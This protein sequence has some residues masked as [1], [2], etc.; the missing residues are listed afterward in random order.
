M[1]EDL[2][3]IANLFIRGS[4]FVASSTLINCNKITKPLT[5]FRDLDYITRANLGRKCEEMI[6]RGEG[7]HAIENY[8]YSMGVDL[9]ADT[10]R[11]IELIIRQNS[12]FRRPDASVLR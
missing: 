1:D 9:D 2:A 8:L 3:R 7:L 6:E 4:I 12:P 5:H 11:G 10:R